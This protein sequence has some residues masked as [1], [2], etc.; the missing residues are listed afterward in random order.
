MKIVKSCVL[1]AVFAATSLLFGGCSPQP[2]LKE[3]IYID[4]PC[5]RATD[6]ASA[7]WLT[8]RWI[9]V[10]IDGVI[11]Y[12]TPDG[13][14]LLGN[15]LSL[16]D[17]NLSAVELRKNRTISMGTPSS[18]S[19]TSLNSAS[20]TAHAHEIKFN[21]N[22]TDIT[23]SLGFDP[24]AP[25]SWVNSPTMTN[26]SSAIEIIYARQSVSTGT[27]AGILISIDGQTRL[28]TS[29]IA[30]VYGVSLMAVIPKGSS[31][32]VSMNSAIAVS[33]RAVYKMSL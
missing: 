27:N 14:A 3:A 7:L 15:L 24:T 4:K 6:R 18:L 23:A 10:E 30:D 19:G 22:W 9:A 31:Y 13:E 12:A 33:A 25:L 1:C 2:T 28:H 11:Y 16:R 5:D 21:R 8:T 26:T 29:H 32:F 17:L 20:G